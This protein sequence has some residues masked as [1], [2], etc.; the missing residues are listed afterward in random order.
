LSDTIQMTLS[1]LPM[2]FWRVL[3]IFANPL[4]WISA[5][6]VGCFVPGVVIGVGQ[7][8]A[9]LFAFFVP[10]VLSHLLFFAAKLDAMRVQNLA[11]YEGRDS[12]VWSWAMPTF[13]LLQLGLCGFLIYRLRTRRLA[14]SLLSIF[15][16]TFAASA[17]LGASI[18]LSI[19]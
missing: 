6:G 2:F 17:L 12:A 19:D 15:T 4:A 10:V 18:F 13:L 1:L 7:R 14:A 5:V 11:Y 3:W 8:S 16:L 9:G